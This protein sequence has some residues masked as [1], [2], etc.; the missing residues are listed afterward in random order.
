MERTLCSV[1][2]SS[3]FHKSILALFV[4]FGN[5]AAFLVPGEKPYKCEFCDYAAAQK[6]SLRY[7]L[8]RHHKDKQ[9]DAAAAAAADVRSDGKAQETEDALLTADGAQTKTMKRV[10]DGAKDVKGSPPAKQLKGMAPAFQNVLGSAVLSQGHRDTQDFNKN[11]TQDSVDKMS[12]TPAPAYLDGL[13]KKAA[14]EPQASNLICPTEVGVTPHPDGSTAHNAD[15]SHKEKVEMAADCK[16]KPSTDCQEK[17]LNLSVGALHNCPAISLSKSLIPSITCPFCTFKTFYPEVL[18]MHQRLEHKYNP[19]SHKNCRSKSWL[20]SR[21]TGCPPALL[22]KD[23]P[24]LSSVPK[25]K[26]KPAFAAQPKSLPSEKGKPGPSGPG[27]V[28]PTSGTDSS[29]LAP[30]NLKSHRPQPSLGVQGAPAARQQLPDM[31]SK[32]GVCP[33][34]EKAKRPEAK[35]RTPAAAQPS[36]GS[37]SLNGSADF[38]AKHDGPWAPPGRDYFCSRSA[39]SAGPEFG[40]PLPKRP[41]PGPGSLDGEQPAPSYRRGF[42]LPKYHV[43]RG[44]ASLLPQEYTCPPPAVLPAKPR[45]LASGEMDSASVLTVHKPYGGAGPL[46]TCG[47]AGPAA[48]AALEGKPYLQGPAAL[49]PEITV[50]PSARLLVGVSGQQVGGG[51]CQIRQWL[52]APNAQP[53]RA[54]P[55]S[56]VLTF[57]V[58]SLPCGGDTEDN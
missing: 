2:E 54:K 19:D 7:H 47:P 34:P 21:R 45:F 8:E 49:P 58:G 36:A 52:V 4:S 17:P 12:K 41:K 15:G 23:V 14:V 16:L 44:V 30:S 28:P 13:K 48:G 26:P 20:K 27:K 24:P 42:D 38:P 39:G 51:G 32:S 37:S 5:T 18:M 25:P 57:S 29:T 6:T 31:F 33:A 10:S 1:F 40:E 56:R 43:V 46:Y 3:S 35:L 11:A 55:P 9:V 53:Y 50:V 22:G